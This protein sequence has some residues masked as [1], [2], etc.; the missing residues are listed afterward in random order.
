VLALG[1]AQRNIAASLVVAGQ[2]FSDPNVVVM[3][4]VVAIVGLIVLIYSPGHRS[5]HCGAE[6]CGT[7]SMIGLRG[8]FA[9][10]RVL[11]LSL[12]STGEF[13]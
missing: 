5:R 13:P 2:A 11:V 10:P 4:V 1:T 8:P 7:D 9:N 12:T 3:V 6:W